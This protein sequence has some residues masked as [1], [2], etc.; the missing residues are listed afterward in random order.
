MWVYAAG[1]AAITVLYWFFLWQYL[2]GIV[3][4]LLGVG[5]NDYFIQHMELC[6]LPNHG[7]S[8]LWCNV[9]SDPGGLFIHLILQSMLYSFAF[10]AFVHP[11]EAARLWIVEQ[12][13]E[14][15]VKLGVYLGLYA[16]F[17]PA[18]R[19]RVAARAMQPARLRPTVHASAAPG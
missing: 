3:P 4:L 12:C 17:R 1:I 15:W 18:N 16:D 8:V 13:V 2:D 5:A 14:L 10:F 9:H 11:K 7:M 19:R 6:K